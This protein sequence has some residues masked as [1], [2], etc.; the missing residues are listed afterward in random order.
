MET[1]VT[2]SQQ[3]PSV[4]ALQLKGNTYIGSYVVRLAD[5]KKYY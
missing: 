5:C 1:L 3:M 2:A 4:H